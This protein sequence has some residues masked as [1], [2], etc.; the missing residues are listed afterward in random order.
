MSLPRASYEREP[1]EKTYWSSASPA[2]ARAHLGSPK[3]R[4]T[5]KFTRLVKSQTPPRRCCIRRRQWDP[6]GASAAAHCCTCAGAVLTE[7]A[8][9][10]SP[11][12]SPSSP[13]LRS[14]PLLHSRSLCPPPPMNAPPISVLPTPTMRLARRLYAK[15]RVTGFKRGAC[16]AKE[17]T[18]LMDRAFRKA[19]PAGAHV[20]GPD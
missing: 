6:R 14:R 4:F 20:F 18:R 8:L 7:F 15:G 17:G 16:A 1:V 3:L 2:L 5:E 13:L 12:P 11:S 19:K 10:Q 9:R